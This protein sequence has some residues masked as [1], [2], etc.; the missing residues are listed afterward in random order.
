VRA[1]RYDVAFYMPSV[2]PLLTR[3]G[4]TGGAETQVFLLSRELARQGLRVCLIV[5]ADPRLEVPSSVCGVEVVSLPPYQPHQHLL[6][7][8]RE[9]LRIGG[10]VR[11]VEARVVVARTAALHVGIVAASAKLTRTAFVFSTANVSDFNPSI[12]LP[13]RRD[14][15][16]YRLGVKLAD[17]VVVQTEEQVHMCQDAFGKKAVLI[18]SIVEPVIPRKRAPESFLWVGRLVSSKRPLAFVE[19]AKS[20]PDVAF[21]MVGV[22]TTDDHLAQQVAAGASRVPNL[23]LL[24]QRPRH[25]L[26][27][28]IDRA[29]AV[30][31]TSQFEGMP[32]VFLEGWSRGVPALALSHD[33]G[34]VIT[35]HRIG[36]FA[37][38]APDMLAAAADDLWRSRFDQEALAARCRSYVR[39]NHSSP[40]IAAQWSEA[41]G[42]AQTDGGPGAAE[43]A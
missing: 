22:R 16:L 34:G 35:R 1:D 36:T 25:Q 37:N 23:E 2:T 6:G 39:E 38:D 31:N 30:V 42:L 32:N 33:P 3:S 40:L 17:A 18:K 11:Q 26:L 13:K 14:R 27:G 20:L 43:V 4:S 12:D 24:T 41:L 5:F 8:V 15:W 19:L 9:A 21:R 10:T 28:L 29:V 7:Q